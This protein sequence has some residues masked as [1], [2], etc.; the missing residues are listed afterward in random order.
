M[1]GRISPACVSGRR[2]DGTVI[3]GPHRSRMIIWTLLYCIC[4]YRTR[5]DGCAKAEPV[6]LPAH[7]SR[8]WSSAIQFTGRRAVGRPCTLRHSPSLPPPIHPAPISSTGQQC[9]RDAGLW[10]DG[11]RSEFQLNRELISW[12]KFTRIL[13]F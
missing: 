6:P 5:C 2:T 3:N 8:R 12:K 9:M 11:P 13:D 7:P 4:R 1:C 10:M